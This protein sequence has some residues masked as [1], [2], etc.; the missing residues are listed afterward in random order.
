MAVKG[1]MDIKFSETPEERRL[2]GIGRGTAVRGRK[3]GG[4]VSGSG[5]ETSFGAR[6]IRLKEPGFGGGFHSGP[7]GC[8]HQFGGDGS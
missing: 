2:P 3:R 1:L 4:A 5:A 8:L 7:K 6:D